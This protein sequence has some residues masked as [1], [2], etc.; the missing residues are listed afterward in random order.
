MELIRIFVIRMDEKSSRTA[1]IVTLSRDN[2]EVH[3]VDQPLWRVRKLYDEEGSDFQGIF[4]Y[5]IS[6]IVG[7]FWCKE[8]NNNYKDKNHLKT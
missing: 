7:H 6:S 2:V 3:N 1:L 5:K 8:A 4:L